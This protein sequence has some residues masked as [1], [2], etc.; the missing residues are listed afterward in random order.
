MKM[1][2]ARRAVPPQASPVG[3]DAVA[4]DGGA[5]FVDGD[6]ELGGPGACFCE[7]VTGIQHFPVAAD[8][9]VYL[10]GDGAVFVVAN[11]DFKFHFPDI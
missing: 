4:Q 5:V 11:R 6:I 2:G 10:D 1:Q 7:F 3:A 8:G 9:F